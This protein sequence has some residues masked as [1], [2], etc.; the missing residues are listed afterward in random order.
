MSLGFLQNGTVM[1]RR[2][3]ILSGLALA[4]SATLGITLW[5]Y[6]LTAQPENR[7]LVLS[8]ILP[9]LLYGALPTDPTAAIA[10]LQRTEQSVSD[11]MP[12]LPVRQQQQLDQLFNLLANRFSRLGLTGYWLTLDNLSASKRLMLLQGWRDSYLAVL[13][14]AYHGLRELLYGAYYGQPEHW[15]NLAYT[16]PRFR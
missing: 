12:F 11:F 3:F 1:H 6:S 10:A 4:G 5:Q 14:Q 15:Q 2:H 16:A 13:Q 8:A 9:A 7:T